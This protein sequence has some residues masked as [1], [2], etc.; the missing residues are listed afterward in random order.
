V[1]GRPVVL[2][3]IEATAIGVVLE[4]IETWLRG[5]PEQVLADLA[6]SA[7]GEHSDRAMTWVGLL[8]GDLR[9]HRGSLAGALRSH[10]GQEQ[11]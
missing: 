2:P 5:A 8:L 1:S 3:A 6:L 9:Y 10:G 11:R 4:I 7:Y